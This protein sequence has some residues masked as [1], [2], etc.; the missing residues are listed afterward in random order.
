MQ[1]GGKEGSCI[2][3]YGCFVARSALYRRDGL[4]SK[5]LY[6]KNSKQD[7]KTS[8]RKLDFGGKKQSSKEATVLSILLIELERAKEQNS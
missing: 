6:V 1:T 3:F 5:D 8:S 2:M 7:L 4:M